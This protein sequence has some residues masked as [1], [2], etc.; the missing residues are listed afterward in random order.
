MHH[1]I[2]DEI[3]LNGSSQNMYI[4]Q[5]EEKSQQNIINNVKGLLNCYVC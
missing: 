1:T 4:L 3:R 2:K 5:C